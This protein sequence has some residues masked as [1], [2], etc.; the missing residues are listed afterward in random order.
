MKNFNKEY[1][2]AQTHNV[3]LH[4]EKNI[5]VGDIIQTEW[6]YF[7]CLP[8]QPHLWGKSKKEYEFFLRGFRHNL[9]T[10]LTTASERKN[11]AR[12]ETFSV[13]HNQKKMHTSTLQL[14]YLTV[15]K[16]YKKNTVN[17]TL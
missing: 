14:K 13:L 12:L 16:K 5:L 15:G 17:F 8:F 9:L 11:G 1:I 7:I 4:Q 3:M 6:D 2:T 10:K